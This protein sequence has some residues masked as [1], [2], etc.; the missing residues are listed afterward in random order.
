MAIQKEAAA[1]LDVSTRRHRDLVK[2][3][4]LP[5]SK[6]PGG[7]DLDAQRVAYIRHLRGVASGQHNPTP[8]SPDL[9]KERARKERAYADKIE[10]ELAIARKEYVHISNVERV[11]EQFATA[12]A[13][14]F[15]AVASRLKHRYPSMKQSQLA[16][17]PQLGAKTFV[18]P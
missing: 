2:S 4:V 16:R 7:Y 11:L 13:D 5:P 10:F 9:T 1:Y 12:A 3:G 14:R 6:G 8:G 17:L 18:S 15:D